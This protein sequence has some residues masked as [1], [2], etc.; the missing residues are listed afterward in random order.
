[1]ELRLPLVSIVMPSFNQVRFLE[2]ALGSVLEQDYPNIE[3]L[4][5]DG[6]STDGSLEVLQQ[7][8]DRLAYWQSRPDE[9]Q[10][11][12]INQGL[13]RTKGKYV[14]WLN[15]D[16]VY[17]P[18]A[19][20]EA[21]E[22]MESNP[23]V[24]MVYA[25]GYMVD[26]ELTLLDRH[27]YPQVDLIDLLCFEVILQPA[28]FMRRATLENVGFLDLSYDLILDHEL[29]VR[30]ASHS[31]LKHIARFW[32]LERT[33]EAAKTIAQADAFVGEAR[34]LI[35]WAWQQPELAGHMLAKKNKVE[36]GLDIFSARR[37]IDAGQS[38]SAI[39]LLWKAAKVDPRS[40]GR[41]WYKVVQAGFSAIGFGWA[42]ELYR[43][44][45]RRVFHRGQKV[46][47]R[48]TSRG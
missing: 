37:L 9:G 24:G 32:C 30:L 48:N 38:R 36:A 47:W 26:A 31:P 43:T 6:G 4:V 1:M 40:V 15:S 2:T 28:V 16:D 46:S 13:Q 14:A 3:L 27:T 17:L 23:E 29:W 7:Y 12:A 33:H 42:F 19:I 10:A 39:R 21:V 11:D 5:I 18:G 22:A 35:E 45:R 20:H 41:Y 34:R 25:D 44:T 8:A